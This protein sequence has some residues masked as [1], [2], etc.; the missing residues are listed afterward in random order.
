MQ[1]LS[2]SNSFLPT[3][4]SSSSFSAPTSSS[5]HTTNPSS[6]ASH[7]TS[8]SSSLSSSLPPLSLAST[9][10]STS[11]PATT[12]A[13]TSSTRPLALPA[14]PSLSNPLTGAIRQLVSG[15]KRRYKADGFDLDLTYLT[16]RL[17][18]M[19]FPSQHL[20]GLYRNPYPEVFRFLETRVC[21]LCCEHA[22]A[23]PRCAGL[24]TCV[25]V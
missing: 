3:N 2:L 5:P 19:G 13:T 4:S 20:E 24:C 11:T 25:C 1:L 9:P 15:N 23:A 6:P 12:T 14:A 16:S 8:A 7:P 17:I 21:V 10:A 22:L 18:A